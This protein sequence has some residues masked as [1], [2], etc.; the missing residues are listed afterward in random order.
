MTC[1]GIIGGRFLFNLEVACLWF[2]LHLVSF[3]DSFSDEELDA[4]SEEFKS[5]SD[6]LEE[7]ADSEELESD[8]EELEDDPE[9]QSFELEDD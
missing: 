5:E 4:D 8:S 3:S 1:S 2:V 6:A 7:D 9:A